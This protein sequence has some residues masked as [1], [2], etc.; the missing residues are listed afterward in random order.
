M[1]NK[2]LWVALLSFAAGVVVLAG[3]MLPVS[4]ELAPWLLF[5]AAVINLALA[6]FF[7]VSG[8]R[9]ARAARAAK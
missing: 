9:A 8:V 4:A 2:E 3:Q 1:M 7:G 5:L 6:T